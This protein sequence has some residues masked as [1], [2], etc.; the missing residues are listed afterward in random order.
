MWQTYQVEFRSRQSYY[1]LMKQA[2]LSW[3]KSQ[4]INPKHDEAAV[5]AKKS[6]SSDFYNSIKWHWS[7]EQ[8]EP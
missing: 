2:G 5:E 1:D 7:R 3:K 4:S 8:C 6:K